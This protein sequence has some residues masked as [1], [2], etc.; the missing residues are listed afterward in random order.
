MSE[1][2]NIIDGD[3]NYI[4]KWNGESWNRLLDELVRSASTLHYVID[5]N[6]C[7]DK[8]FEELQKYKDALLARAE[9]AEQM[10]KRLIEVCSP[11]A[12]YYLVLRNGMPTESKCVKEFEA[13]V[14]E[15]QARND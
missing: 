4:S 12:E 2:P 6:E 10:V 9:R 14:A 1:L 11:M 13:L 5:D 7:P 15:W 3:V 8:A